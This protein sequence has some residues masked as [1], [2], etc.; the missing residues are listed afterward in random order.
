[1]KEIVGTN[2]TSQSLAKALNGGKFLW[3]HMVMMMMMMMMVMMMMMM[4]MMV[5]VMMMM[6][7]M[8]LAMINNNDNDDVNIDGGNTRNQVLMKQNTRGHCA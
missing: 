1:L 3:G 5:M 4:M 7:M 2:L 8:M 6:V